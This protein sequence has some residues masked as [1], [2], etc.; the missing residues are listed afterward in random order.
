MY[1][2]TNYYDAFYRQNN[3]LI[4]EVEKAIHCEYNAIHCYAKLANLA[5]DE[6]EKNRILEIRKDEIK[7]HH[8]FEQI[9]TKLT[10]RKPLQPKLSE[11][12]PDGYLEGLEIALQDE[13]ITVDFYHEVADGTSDS[14]IKEAFRRAAA[15]EQNHAVWFL[16]FFAKHK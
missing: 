5:S 16:Y 9:Y 15:D 10:G 12:C 13:Q 8:Q 4:K 1:P 14:L 2:Y 6:K 7:H 11:E 3:K